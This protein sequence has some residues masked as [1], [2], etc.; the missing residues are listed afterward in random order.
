MISKN[1]MKKKKKSLFSSLNM[2][3]KTETFVCYVNHTIPIIEIYL[4][5]TFIKIT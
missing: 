1:T 3:R 2:I 5:E 4:F